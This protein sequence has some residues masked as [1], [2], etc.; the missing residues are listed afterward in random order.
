LKALRNAGAHTIAQD[1]A[2]SAVYG[3]PKAA[4]QLNAA[5]EVLP[6]DQIPVAIVRCCRANVG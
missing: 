3:M 5:V 1:Q 6:L 2:T 4:V